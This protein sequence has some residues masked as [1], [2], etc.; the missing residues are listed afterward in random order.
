MAFDNVEG[1]RIN[2]PVQL[3]GVPCGRVSGMSFASQPPATSPGVAIALESPGSS[4]VQVVLSLEVP[5]SI[6]NLLRT[7]SEAH[8]LKTLTGMTVVDLVQGQGDPLGEG[9]RIQG[10]E[11]VSVDDVT[12]TLNET[13]KL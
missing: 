1:F 2:D 5:E 8:I 9:D 12:I 10:R 6:F 13:G 11:P 4:D 3:H 7:G